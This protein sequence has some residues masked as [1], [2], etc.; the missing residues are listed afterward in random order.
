MFVDSA[1]NRPGGFTFVFTALFGWVLTRDGISGLLDVTKPWR[2]GVFLLSIVTGLYCGYRAAMLLFLFTMAFQFYFEGLCRLRNLAIVAGVV[3]VVGAALVPNVQ[4]LP[5]VIQRT[6][7]FLPLPVNPV[8]KM[9][10]EISSDWRWRMWQDLLPSVPKYA[11]LGKGY[12]FDPDEQFQTMAGINSFDEG[13]SSSTLAGDYHSG[14][15]SLMI[16]FGLAGFCGFVWFVLASLKYM[17]RAMRNG[18]PE[19]RPLNT[20]LLAFFAARVAQYCLVYGMFP[21]DIAALAGLVGFSVSLNGREIEESVEEEAEAETTGF[22]QEL[23][24]TE[25]V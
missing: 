21:I 10:A 3:I 6:L 5:F 22:E 15:L 1:I 20:L 12:G 13:F 9:D 25:L 8:V 18:D 14:P 11:L 17:Y 16:S 23:A 19:L 4:K 7:S 2:L 24:P